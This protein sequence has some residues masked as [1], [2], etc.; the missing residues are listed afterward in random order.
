MAPLVPQTRFTL[1]YIRPATPPEDLYTAIKSGLTATPKQLPS[2]LLWDADGHKLFER[3]T[4]STS[5][6]G[7]RAD[8]DIMVEHMDRLC[9]M[10]GEDGILLELGS[11]YVLAPSLAGP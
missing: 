4:K 10:I 7:T 2:L 5:Y 8:Q 1:Q 9:D 6:Y 3:I 11:G